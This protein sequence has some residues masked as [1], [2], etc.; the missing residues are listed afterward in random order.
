MSKAIII[1]AWCG[2]G[3]THFCRNTKGA[4]EFECWKYDKESFPDNE[5]RDIEDQRDKVDYIFISTNIVALDALS[6]KGIEYILVYPQRG[7]KEEYLNRYRERGSH[8]DFI[9]TMD[10]YWDGWMTEC[11]ENT[12]P[13]E[14]YRLGAGEYIAEI[15]QLLRH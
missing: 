5:L 1:A 8:I 12:Q 9:G 4:I 14:T 11:E 15:H 3:K 2:T 6:E 7:L 10:R 13:E